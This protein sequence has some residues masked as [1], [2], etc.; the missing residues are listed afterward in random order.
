M[1]SVRRPS[2]CA[3]PW[4]HEQLT[5]NDSYRSWQVLSQALLGHAPVRLG[6]P[7]SLAWLKGVFAKG[8][9][10]FQPFFGYLSPV[11]RTCS[12][13]CVVSLRPL[14][15]CTFLGG[16]FAE[17]TLLQKRPLVRLEEEIPQEV[18]RDPET[19]SEPPGIPLESTAGM[20]QTQ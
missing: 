3:E 1:E 8:C 11:R 19:L 18:R 2:C 13:I 12:G 5:R 7:G 20:L 9:F 6:L 17:S 14:P 15:P 4:G 16:K 10:G